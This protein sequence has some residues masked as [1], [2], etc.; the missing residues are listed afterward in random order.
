MGRI[1]ADQSQQVMATLAANVNWR[2]IDFDEAMMQKM[3]ISNPRMAGACFTRFLKNGCRFDSRL[4]ATK[5]FNPTE[6]IGE[7]WTIWKGPADGD[8]LTGEED[9]DPRSLSIVVADPSKFLFESCLW[10]RE[11][12]IVGEERLRRL[13]ALLSFVRFGGNVFLGLLL[14]YG[15]NV[16]NSA[17][18]WLYQNRGIT[19]MDFLGL[20]LRDPKGN[21]CALGL[22][23][24][25][26]D[27]WL[28]LYRYQLSSPD[29]RADG[30]TVGCKE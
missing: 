3:I 13:K 22:Y 27:G 24:H 26:N 25:S 30:A 6:F 28:P 9:V 5:S 15:E 10:A 1:T 29:W 18:E 20:V 2:E 14:D 4:F 19:K 8:G 7:G 12:Q 11:K 16:E 17:L 23:R 21:R